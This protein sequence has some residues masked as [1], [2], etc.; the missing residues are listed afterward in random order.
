MNTVPLTEV[1][2]NLRKIVDDVV[3]TGDEYVITRHGKP[4][5]VV[6]SYDEYESL[7]ESLNLL[8]DNAAMAAIAEGLAEAKAGRT[9][10]LDEV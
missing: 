2:D 3:K 10:D 4:Q 8:S 1:R 7:L 9:M 6:I 5:A